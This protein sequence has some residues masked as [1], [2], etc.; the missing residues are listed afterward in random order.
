MENAFEAPLPVLTNQL[1]IDISA[2]PPEFSS[3]EL[4]S[5]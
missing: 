3:D 4:Q 5:Q 1:R 2:A